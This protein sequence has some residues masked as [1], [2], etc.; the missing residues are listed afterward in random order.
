MKVIIAVLVAALLAP[1]VAHAD[2]RVERGGIKWLIVSMLATQAADIATTGLALQRGCVETSYYG[3]QNKWAIGGIK[4]GGALALG[5][6]LPFAHNKKPKLTK[7]LLWSQIAS[8]AIG[9]TVNSTR[10]PHCR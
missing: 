6:T 10:L 4:G 8:G 5:L 1:T 7:A 9:A 3:L 2:D